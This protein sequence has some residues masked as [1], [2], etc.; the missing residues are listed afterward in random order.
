MLF[1]FSRAVDMVEL[2]HLLYPQHPKPP[3]RLRPT[4]TLTTDESA[5]DLIHQAI[6]LCSSIFEE[7]KTTEQPTEKT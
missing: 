7:P 6:C 3:I 2:S 5:P 4:P 1:E